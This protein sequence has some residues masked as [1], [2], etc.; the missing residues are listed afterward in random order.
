[1][2][3]EGVAQYR[4]VL[5]IMRRRRACDQ[6]DQHS[7]QLANLDPDFNQRFEYCKEIQKYVNV[8]KARGFERVR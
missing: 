2:Y 6:A 1:M 8:W 5:Q 4:K 3:K 7:L